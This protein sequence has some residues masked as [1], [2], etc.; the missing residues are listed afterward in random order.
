MPWNRIPREIPWREVGDGSIFNRIPID[1]EPDSFWWHP[2][3]VKAAYARSLEYSLDT[4][5]S[6][7]QHSGNKNLVLLVVGDEQPLPVVSG[8]GASHDVPI[9]VI[10]HDPAVLNR[11]GGWGWEAGLRPKPQA[12]VWRMD[13]VRDRFLSAFGPQAGR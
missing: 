7:V 6:F 1:R 13:A 9:S 11:I 4:L 5:I 3:Q 2:D 12:P 10:A 8:Q